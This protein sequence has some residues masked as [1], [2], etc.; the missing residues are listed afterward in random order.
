MSD[1]K[2]ARARKA[3][4]HV[5]NMRF[6]DDDF[7]EIARAESEELLPGPSSEKEIIAWPMDLVHRARQAGSRF[8]NLVALLQDGYLATSDYSGYDCPREMVTQLFK[9]LKLTNSFPTLC[10][11]VCRFT[12]ACDNDKLPLKVLTFLAEEVDH[13]ESCVN[14][15]IENCL[16]D[17]TKD[18]LDEMVPHKEKAKITK[19][20]EREIKEAY[21]QMMQWLIQNRHTAFKERCASECI[22]HGH[23]C[24][25]HPRQTSDCH[26][27][28]RVNWGGNECIGWSTVGKQLRYAHASERTFAIWVVQRII[29]AENQKE[30]GF[31]QDRCILFL[32]CVVQF[33]FDQECTR[34]F[35]TE[36][37][38][39]IPLKD[40]FQV[41]W[42]KV[43]GT[44][45]GFPSKRERRLSFN[46]NHLRLR[47]IGP[48][49]QKDIQADFDNLFHR[50]IMLPGDVY[51]AAPA[52]SVIGMYGQKMKQR[53]ANLPHDQNVNVQGRGMLASVLTPGQLQRIKAYEDE[54]QSEHGHPPGQDSHLIVDSMQ[55]PHMPGDTSGTL[56]PSQL[57]HGLYYSFT[58]RRLIL[59]L[60][61]MFANGWNVFEPEGATFSSVLTPMLRKLSEN[62]IKQLSGNGMMLPAIGAWFLYV[63]MNTVRVESSKIMEEHRLA[64][65][66]VGKDGAESEDDVFDQKKG[67]RSHES[68]M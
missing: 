3:Q 25:G 39:T 5:K 65:L 44:H 37:K 59:G 12:R 43:C 29:Q 62:Q 32:S 21:E 20:E 34:Y 64:N 16:L 35:P 23:E 54:Y 57:K 58:A 8:S 4:P 15:N 6:E 24:P 42:V 56:F 27:A 38:M 26:G 17:E 14:T 28:L 55:W 68:S 31:F 13:C 45:L 53:F 19:P 33:K 67:D 52:D 63:C 51:C 46:A 66:H 48:T 36:Q 9:A 49:E 41:V 61:Y 11:P 7:E 40:W 47:W 22:I 50:A 10:C 60:E 1:R 30:D 2:R 18:K